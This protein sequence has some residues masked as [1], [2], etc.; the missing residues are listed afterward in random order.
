MAEVLPGRNGTYLDLLRTGQRAS[1]SIRGSVPFDIAKVSAV[2]T[3]WA[4]ARP[5]GCPGQRGE[6]IRPH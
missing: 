3:V 5:K 4:K 2:N 1:S 6:V